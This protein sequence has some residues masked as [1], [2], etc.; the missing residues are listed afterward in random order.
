MRFVEPELNRMS[1]TAK[2]FITPLLTLIS[3]HIDKN[4]ELLMGDSCVSQFGAVRT[5]DPVQGSRF[6]T[7][8]KPWPRSNDS[9]ARGVADA[10]RSWD[11]KGQH[12]LRPSTG[13]KPHTYGGISTGTKPR[14]PDGTSAPDHPHSTWPADKQSDAQSRLSFDFDAITGGC[15]T[16]T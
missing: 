13:T 15:V 8:G 11:R 5:Q 14:R 4:I 9:H 7:C 12:P 3:I 16:R 1:S 2:S 6:K 10:L